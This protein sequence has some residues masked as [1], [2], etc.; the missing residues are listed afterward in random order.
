VVIIASSTSSMSDD[1][2]ENTNFWND[3]S[4]LVAGGAGFIGG[5]LVQRLL[6]LEAR[7]TV[8]DNLENE[9][10]SQLVNKAADSLRIDL[11]DARSCQMACKDADVVYN[12]AAKVAGVSY[13]SAH[14]GE[15][16]HR[17]ALVNLNMLEAARKNDV[18]RYV[19][20]SSACVYKRDVEVPTVEDDG[21]L[22]DP[23][24]SNFGY[25]WAKRMAEVQARA[26]ASEYGMKISIIRPYNT[27]GPRDHF[28]ES[29]SHVIPSLI[30][31]IISD[32]GEL[33]VWGTGQQ[34]RSF[35]YVSDLVQGLILSPEHY[36]RPDPI[37]IGSDEEVSIRELAELIM[38]LSDKQKPVQYDVTKPEG[39]LRR[40]PSLEKARRLLGYSPR[41]KLRE[42]L[43]LTIDWYTQQ[44]KRPESLAPKARLR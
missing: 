4:V 22:G 25:G 42:G 19:V 9:S 13:N 39:Q 17:N 30:R 10:G 8:A 5:H 31:K 2:G 16:F 33:V 37:N 23:E 44:I 7:V 24:P 11:A 18:D 35:V 27:Y 40:S 43:K 26:Y 14:S 21:F 32:P 29:T 6:A 41:A 38:T 28:D 15:M 34:K 1:A 36:P 3:R 20:F 12:A